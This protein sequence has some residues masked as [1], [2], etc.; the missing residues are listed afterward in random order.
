M[1]CKGQC[2]AKKHSKCSIGESDCQP[3]PDKGPLA[4]DSQRNPSLSELA[5]LDDQDN[6]D[7]YLYVIASIAYRDRRFRQRGTGPNFQGGLITLCTCKHF[8]RSSMDVCEWRGKWI[9]GFTSKTCVKEPQEGNYL[10]YLMKVSEAFESFDKLWNNNIPDK[11]KKAKAAHL[12]RLGDVYKPTHEGIK[13]YK[14]DEYEPPCTNHSHS[15]C[16]RTDI[17]YGSGHSGRHAALLVGDKKKSFLWDKPKIRYP[18]QLPRNC[19]KL[20]LNDLLD[21][22]REV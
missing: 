5:S 15:E 8:M 1:R 13:P 11:T 10:V 3:F 19:Q 20:K 18:R 22:L 9:A 7:V 12:H 4:N 21:R 14:A 17:E 16:W 2:P 6:P